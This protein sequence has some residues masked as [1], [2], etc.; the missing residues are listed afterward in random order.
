MKKDDL[1]KIFVVIVI[2]SFIVGMFAYGG[3]GDYG[4]A[5][6]VETPTPT[7]SYALFGSAT[8]NA[9]IL[10]YPDN[11]LVIYGQGAG[12]DQALAERLRQ[13]VRDGKAAY[14]NSAGG[15]TLN[16]ILAGNANITDV[17]INLTLDFP[18]ITT[19]AKAQLGFP[20]NVTFATASGDMTAPMG[21]RPFISI[22]PLVTAGRNMS[23][24]LGAMIDPQ[25]S[26]ISEFNMQVPQR[27]GSA[28]VNSTVTGLNATWE[29]KAAYA[30]ER[31]NFNSSGLEARLRAECPNSSFAYHENP[32]ILLT[33]NASEAEA[34][35]LQNLSYVNIV[36]GKSVLVDSN[37]TNI[38][39]AEA[40]VG[41]I[42]NG[43]N[44]TF[45]DA[46]VEFN[47]T[48]CGPAEGFFNETFSD[49]K[50][51]DVGRRGTV[52]VGNWVDIG[53]ENYILPG[54]ASFE[55]ILPMNASV[56]SWIEIPVTVQ[57]SGI[58]IVSLG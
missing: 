43:T 10:A 55:V 58:R 11:I 56:G 38:S 23:I 48:L 35:A 28:L 7:P 26:S 30:W 27:E 29:M 33:A 45:P 36:I 9:T 18:G 4:P 31:R 17:A 57:L 42:L 3:G 16:L 2:V 25:T 44:F 50:G 37:F 20:E 41:G 12:S 24:Q 49:A 46:Y 34:S 32:F 52:A 39:R 13:L 1:I 5:G 51:V 14:V 8:L 19:K 47:A 40:D 22:E 21:R 15:D 6:G 53:G 54:G